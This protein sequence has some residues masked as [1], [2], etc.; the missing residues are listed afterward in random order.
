[1]GDCNLDDI[2]CQLQA[3]NS[4]EALQSALGNEVFLAEWPELEGLPEKLA[5]KIVNARGKLESAVLECQPD[6]ISEPN[7]LEE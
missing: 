7:D 5:S 1:M 3:L 6:E 4:M 2:M